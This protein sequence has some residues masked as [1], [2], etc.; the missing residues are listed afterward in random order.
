[1]QVAG[2]AGAEKLLPWSGPRRSTIPTMHFGRK[3]QERRNIPTIAKGV[4]CRHRVSLVGE[5]EEIERSAGTGNSLEAF[6]ELRLAGIFYATT[7]Q[8]QDF[9]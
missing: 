3:E 7:D 1:M 6:F 5:H 9:S 8:H 4:N 2:N